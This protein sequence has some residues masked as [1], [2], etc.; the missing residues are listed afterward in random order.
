MAGKDV[1][2]LRHGLSNRS[3]IVH[4]VVDGLK[5]CI[6]ALG[7]EVSVNGGS[8]GSAVAEVV[9]DKPEID[10]CLQQMSSVAV[11]E[12]MDT[13]ILID[14]AFLEC[15]FENEPYTGPWHG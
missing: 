12:R 4:E 10:S 8:G 7:R 14:F 15:I 6:F 9:L 5:G 3:K 2:Q 1:R 11:P 13:G